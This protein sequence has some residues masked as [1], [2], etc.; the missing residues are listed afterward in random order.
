MQSHEGCK[1]LKFEEIVVTVSTGGG[2]IASR[3]F[4]G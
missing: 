1:F 2:A 4:V 3:C